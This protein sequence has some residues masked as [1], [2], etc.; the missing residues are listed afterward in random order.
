MA[1]IKP[2]RSARIDAKGGG[3]EAVGEGGGGERHGMLNTRSVSD[4]NYA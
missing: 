3:A 1:D 4:I 2:L